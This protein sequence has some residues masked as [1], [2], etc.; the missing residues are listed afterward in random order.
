MKRIFTFFALFLISSTVHAQTPQAIPYQAAAR[1]SSGAVLASTPISVRF[2]VRDSMP[3]GAI[4]YRE[5][6]SVTTTADGMFSVNIGQGTP[7]SGTFTTINWSTNAKYT[8]VEIDP[9]GGSSYVVMGT[10]QMMSVPY[11]LYAAN[12][13]QGPQGVGIQTISAQGNNLIITFTN[14]EIQTIPFPVSQ[15]SN[16]HSNTLIYTTNGF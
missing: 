2:T 8:Q 7:V 3:S 4:K 15:T 10:Q 11:A 9:A 1:N 5:T 6:H 16:N 14:G 12:S 13:Q